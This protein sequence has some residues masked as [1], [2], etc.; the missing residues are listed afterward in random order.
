MIFDIKI[1]ECFFKIL[2]FDTNAIKPG[3]C[4]R[5]QTWQPSDPKT[6]NVWEKSHKR[7]CKGS[8]L[9]NKKCLGI[10][11]IPRMH[12]TRR[13]KMVPEAGLEPARVHHSADF[14]SAASTI[15][16]H[17]RKAHYKRLDNLGQLLFVRPKFDRKRISRP[18]RFVGDPDVAA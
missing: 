6:Q 4:K 7:S 3:L 9:S 1:H 8:Y 16:P 2:I 12:Q 5:L 18:R 10:I 14:E 17:G 11:G 15:P 13:F